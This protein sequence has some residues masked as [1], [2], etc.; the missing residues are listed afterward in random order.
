MEIDR[1]AENYHQVSSAFARLAALTLASKPTTGLEETVDDLSAGLFTL[2]Q[3]DLD[4][5]WNWDA[6]KRHA[7]CKRINKLHGEAKG[8]V[9]RLEAS[10][11]A[12]VDEA[13]QVIC[14]AADRGIAVVQEALDDAK[15]AIHDETRRSV[16]SIALH[17]ASATRQTPTLVELVQTVSSLHSMV[18]APPSDH[19]SFALQSIRNAQAD[20][21]QKFR[22]LEL[23]SGT[24]GSCAPAVPSGVSEQ[25]VQSMIDAALAKQ[26]ALHQQA[27]RDMCAE[28]VST[29]PGSA[30]GLI[31]IHDAESVKG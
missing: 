8:L 5:M 26:E 9:D 25:N 7:L 21:E 2:L 3:G 18:P 28:L 4:G 12:R 20:L 19:A 23:E 10:T 30:H 11:S 24:L 1:R 6:E 31:L 29:T 16:N 27:M 22:Q 13:K 15:R 17:V 14:Q